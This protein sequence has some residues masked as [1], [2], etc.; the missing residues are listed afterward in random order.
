MS[1]F[2]P[3]NLANY[4]QKGKFFLRHEWR[5]KALR[6]TEQFYIYKINWIHNLKYYSKDSTHTRVYWYIVLD[7]LPYDSDSSIRPKIKQKRKN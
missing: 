6:N 4:N 1:N 5:Q 7:I 2:I 3:K